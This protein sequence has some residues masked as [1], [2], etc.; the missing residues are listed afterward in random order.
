VIPEPAPVS[1][2]EA[3]QR[4]DEA[5]HKAW[6]RCSSE[7]T[8]LAVILIAFDGPKNTEGEELL[9]RALHVH[10]ARTHDVVLRRSNDQFAAIL[11]DTSPAGARLIGERILEAM[12]SEDNGGTHRVSAGITVAVPD[13]QS[14]PANL[15]H[16]AEASLHAAQAKGGDRCV[17]GSAITG[18]AAT[19]SPSGALS[20]LGKLF[21]KK[22]HDEDLRRGTD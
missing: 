15:L 8:P 19:K 4:L 14:D 20:A 6:F 7:S 3:R 13:E 10:C 22:K 16:H 1:A 5:L 11:P 12:R 2:L 9:E 17:G 21:Q 18:A